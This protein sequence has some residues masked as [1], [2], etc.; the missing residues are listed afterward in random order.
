LSIIPRG[1]MD[2][3]YWLLIFR[4]LDGLG[5]RH[6]Y[7]MIPENECSAFVVAVMDAHA[8]IGVFMV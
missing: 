3:C 7:D 5:L 6:G 4:S 1:E 8:F 2:I